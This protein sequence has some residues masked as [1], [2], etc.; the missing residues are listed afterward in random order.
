MSNI[1]PCTLSARGG[2]TPTRF[3]EDAWMR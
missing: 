2:F 3:E 1:E